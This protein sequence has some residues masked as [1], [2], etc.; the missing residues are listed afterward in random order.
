MLCY[1]TPEQ[2]VYRQFSI[3]GHRYTLFIIASQSHYMY[4]HE[5]RAASKCYKIRK[6]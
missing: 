3:T 1:L 5:A 4:D 6:I 2:K